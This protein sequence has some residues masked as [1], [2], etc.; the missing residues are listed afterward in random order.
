MISVVEPSLHNWQEEEMVK[1]QLGFTSY[2]HQHNL[3]LNFLKSKWSLATY[4][5]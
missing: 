1:T 2:K 5:H 4:A 3:C